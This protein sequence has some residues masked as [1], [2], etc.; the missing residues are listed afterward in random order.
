MGHN[1]SQNGRGFKA[2]LQKVFWGW[3]EKGVGDE[4]KINLVLVSYHFRQKHE[5]I[6]ASIMHVITTK[7]YHYSKINIFE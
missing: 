6:R 4:H 3:G 1:I 5:I 2:I 7:S